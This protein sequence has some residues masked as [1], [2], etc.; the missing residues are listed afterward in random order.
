MSGLWIRVG[1]ASAEVYMRLSSA[2]VSYLRILGYP[3]PSTFFYL[4]L[5]VTDDYHIKAVH[6]NLP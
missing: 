4:F 1:F 6:F 2:L 5:S 3:V